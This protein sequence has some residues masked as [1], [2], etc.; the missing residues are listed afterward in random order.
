MDGNGG[1]YHTAYLRSFDV[2]VHE[3]TGAASCA[4]LATGA[5]LL[6]MPVVRSSKREPTAIMRSDSGLQ[7]WQAAPC[8]PNMCID[9]G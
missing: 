9:C 8:M 1:V 2:E 5:Y 3:A 7:N 6:R 4:A